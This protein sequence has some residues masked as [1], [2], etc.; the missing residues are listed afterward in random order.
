MAIIQCPEC[1]QEISDKAK[2][3]IHC[4]KILIEEKIPTKICSECGKEVPINEEECPYC[5]C[6][7][8]ETVNEDITLAEKTEP[9]E[10]SKKKS[11]KIIILIAALVVIVLAVLIPKFT[12]KHA[13]SLL[14]QGKYEDAN[15]ILNVI[16]WYSDV[17]EIQEQLKYE[18]YAYSAINNLKQYLKNP[19][20]F[21]P[22]EIKFY[23]L[24][25]TG[26]TSDNESDDDEKTEE[27]DYPV[28]IMNYGAQNGFG[29]NSTGYA[30]FTYDED[31]GGYTLLGT[32]DSLDE[33]DY[34]A[35][36]DEEAYEL[37]VCRLVNSYRSGDKSVGDVDL[38]RLKTVLKNDA[39]STIKI[40]K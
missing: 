12:Y 34:D 8:E 1:G 22:Y 2:K 5:G 21:Q 10:K 13:V 6:P 27:E 38:G 18:S 15:K 29:G 7:F 19:D 25:D 3:C 20:S 36:D 37:I 9:V 31:E 26:E 4:G 35:S 23:N 17:D 33:D 11:K 39:Y 14:E 40:I 24:I 16:R 30:M 28:C 32:C